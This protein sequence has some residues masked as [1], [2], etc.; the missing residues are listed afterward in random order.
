LSPEFCSGIHAPVNMSLA[1]PTLFWAGLLMKKSLGGGE[2]C[3]PRVRTPDGCKK[4]G[5]PFVSRGKC[6]FWILF[7]LL[8]AKKA[9]K[10][11]SGPPLASWPFYHFLFPCPLLP[12]PPTTRSYGLGNPHHYITSPPIPP[13]HTSPPPPFHSPSLHPSPWSLLTLPSHPSTPSPPFPLF[14]SLQTPTPSLLLP[15]PAP[16]PPPFT[17]NFPFGS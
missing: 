13:P 14:I 8:K 1:S 15:F 4:M 16:P 7:S 11:S 9:G 2:F 6:T 10:E 5:F 3:P 17:V 12:A